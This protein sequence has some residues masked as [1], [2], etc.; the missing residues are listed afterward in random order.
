MTA[1]TSACSSAVRNTLLSS[2][3]LARER[4]QESTP[5]VYYRP[6]C[7]RSHYVTYRAA[8]CWN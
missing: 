1:N 5:K 3:K 2:R 6:F 8:P 4:G 7:R